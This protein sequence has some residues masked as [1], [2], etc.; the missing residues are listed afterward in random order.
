MWSWAGWTHVTLY[1]FSVVASLIMTIYKYIYINTYMVKICIGRELNICWFRNK[2]MVACD[3]VSC[4]SL[5]YLYFWCLY[6]FF[7]QTPFFVWSHANSHRN[8]CL[9]HYDCLKTSC[10]CVK[11]LNTLKTKRRLLYLKIQIVLR[12]KHFSSRL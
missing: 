5:I 6:F 11:L 8:I 2:Y 12:S 4:L 10:R 1:L 3:S 7:L 9:N